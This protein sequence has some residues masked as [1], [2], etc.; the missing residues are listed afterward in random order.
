[1][2]KEEKTN[3]TEFIF[4]EIMKKYGKTTLAVK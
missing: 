1:M 4:Q 2:T 3:I